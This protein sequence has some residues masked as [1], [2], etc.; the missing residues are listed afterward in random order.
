MNFQQCRYVIAIADAGSFSEAAKRLFV[1]QP[2]LSASIHQLEDELGVQLFVRSNTGTRL[3]DDGYDFIKYAKRIIGEL[4]LLQNR[5]HKDFKKS[6][7]VAS[8]HY[9][10]LS[11]ALAAISEQFSDSHQEFQLVETT[12]K[13]IIDSVASFQSDLGIIYLDDSSKAILERSFK[14][15]DLSFIPLGDFQT[16]IFLSEKHPLADRKELTIA[17]LQG[18]AQIRFSQDDSGMT[19]DED[20]LAIEDGQKVIYANDRGSLMNMLLATQA[21]ASGLGIVTG[22]VKKHIKLVPLSDSPVHTLGYVISNQKKTSEIVEA[23]IDK[24]KEELTLAQ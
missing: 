15:K 17:D 18:Y 16:K 22:F 20:P 14:Q 6:F 5:Y 2:N 9:D 7:V 3:T 24:V 4:D 23:F 19:F 13:A 1:S 12:T 21:Y 8:H 11:Q 10:F